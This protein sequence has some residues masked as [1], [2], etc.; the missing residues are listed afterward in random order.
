[1]AIPRHAALPEPPRPSGSGSP[2]S[3]PTGPGTTRKSTGCRCCC[4]SSASGTTRPARKT[5]SR[6]SRRPSWPRS[7]ARS[8]RSSRSAPS[9]TPW[10]PPRPRCL[11]RP[12]RPSTSAAAR[13]HYAVLCDFDTRRTI[14]LP[15]GDGPSGSDGR[16]HGTDGDDG[17]SSDTHHA[18]EARHMAYTNPTVSPRGTTFAQ[19]QAGGA[20]GHLETTDR[21]PG[22]RPPA[23]TVAPTAAAT[24]GGAPAACWRPAR[25][26][27]SSPR[28]TASARRPPGPESTQLTRRRDQH[29]ADHVPDLEDRQ[30]GP[31]PL[32]G[33]VGGLDT[34]ARTTSTP[35][36]SRPRRTTWRPPSPTNCYA[37]QPPTVNSTGLTYTDAQRQRRSTSRSSWS[38]PP[39]TA[40]SRTSTVPTAASSTTSTAATRSRSPAR[41]RSSARP[42]GLRDARDALLRDGH[43]DRRQP[44]HAPLRDRR[45]ES[46]RRTALGPEIRASSLVLC[47]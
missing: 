5:A 37:V 21:R 30:H 45:S 3:W 36:A 13:R 28:P 20:S 41:S 2:R 10:P 23:P 25:T 18:P 17:R 43:A 33:A 6:S 14:P 35:A 15:L 26:T 24:G 29:S 46:R 27:S 19:F 11:T 7:G 9:S 4:P 12:G 1:M 47:P 32:P 22:R 38:A 40:T 16:R 34:A 42:H 39:R 31:E 44:R 8:S